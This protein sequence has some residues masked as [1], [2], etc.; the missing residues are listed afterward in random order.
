MHSYSAIGIFFVLVLVRFVVVFLGARGLGHAALG[1]L[2]VS[3][4]PSFARSSFHSAIVVSTSTP[5]KPSSC[6]ASE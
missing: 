1:S 3:G 6:R 5:T 4:K 2:G